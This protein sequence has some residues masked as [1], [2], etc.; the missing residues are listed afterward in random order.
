VFTKV[1]KVRD[2]RC[3]FCKIAD[4]NQML[5]SRTVQLN[6]NAFLLEQAKKVAIV[7]VKL[8]LAE[9]TVAQHVASDENVRFV[10]F[11]VVSGGHFEELVKFGFA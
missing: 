11:F 8:D 3:N 2:V 6:K 7:A 9:C 1:G 10:V 4:C 5:D